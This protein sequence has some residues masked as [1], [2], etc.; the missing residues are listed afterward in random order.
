[1]NGANVSGINFTGAAQTWSISGTITPSSA[2][3][4]ATVSLSG[5]ASA[6]VT[7][8]A[9]GNFIFSG[10][11]NGSYTVMP[12]EAGY[13]FNPSSQTTAISGA[14]V[15]GVNFTAQTAGTQTLAVDAISSQGLTTKATTVSTAAFSTNFGNELLLAFIAG[16][17]LSGTN[18]TVTGVTGAGLTWALVKRTNVQSGTAELW[19]AF[20]PTSLS[21]VTVTATL[22][23]SVVSSITVM[24]FSGVDGTGSNGSGAIGAT[25]TANAKTGAPSASLVSTRN[26]SLMLGVGNDF[27]NAIARTVGPAQSLVYQLLTSTGDT[28]WVQRQTNP[29]PVSGTAVTINDTAPMSDRY[30]LSLVEVLPAG[31]GGVATP[32]NVSVTS[33]AP[34]ATVSGQTTISASASDPYNSILGVQFLVDGSN[35]GAEGNFCSLLVNLGHDG[36]EWNTHA[37]CGR[38]Q[39]RRPEC[40]IRSDYSHRQQ[41]R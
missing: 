36:F 21:G 27:D 31:S 10:L 12:T 19:R 16:D 24:S 4:G 30:N 22:S 28:Y 37:G 23:Q 6:T 7:P 35:L 1:M 38:V 2:A 15:P 13:T 41:F 14:S 17:Y 29:T 39:L 33:P 32:P 34:N 5:P 18:T 26:N 11:A 25:A 3:T 40:H 20:A 9:S 8:N